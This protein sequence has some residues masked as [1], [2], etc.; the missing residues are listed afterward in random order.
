MV[1]GRDGGK[2]GWWRIV[3][4]KWIN[5]EHRWK[6]GSI[7][8]KTVKWDGNE[9]QQERFRRRFGEEMRLDEMSRKYAKK[10][11]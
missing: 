8:L 11:S 4:D 6:Y 5:R 3:N 9:K 7:A 1:R 10:E 2:V